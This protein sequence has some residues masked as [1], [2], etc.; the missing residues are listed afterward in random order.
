M[1]RFA[2]QKHIGFCDQFLKITIGSCIMIHDTT[3]NKIA[4]I[5]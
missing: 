5:D 4:F 1:K 3:F 2:S